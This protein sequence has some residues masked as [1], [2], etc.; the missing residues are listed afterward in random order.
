[1]YCLNENQF[2]KLVDFV[3][4]D[5]FKLTTIIH[6]H[7]VIQKYQKKRF[8]QRCVEFGIMKL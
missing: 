8:I 7:G 2:D 1:L 4:D 3:S 5:G 6:N